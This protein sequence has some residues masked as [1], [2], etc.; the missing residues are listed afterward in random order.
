MSTVNY[1]KNG[2]LAVILGFSAS[3]SWAQNMDAAEFVDEATAKGI[4]EIEAAKLAIE[5]GQNPEIK[6][7]AERMIEDHTEMNQK[8][9]ELAQE[10]QL[11]VS[12][13]A[14]LMDQ[15][16]AMILEMRDGEGFDDHYAS[17]QVN[18]HEQTIELFENASKNLTDEDLKQLATDNLETLREH[19]AKAKE[20]E[21][22]IEAE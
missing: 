12:D 5:Q 18:A 4:A 16:K 14:T 22:Q 10:K 21:S 2:M 8:L 19:L 11:E 15:A 13:D 6:S 1:I 7:F 17:N 9:K 3:A 20:L